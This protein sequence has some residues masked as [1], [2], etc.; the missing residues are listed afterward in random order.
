MS[1]IMI[2]DLAQSRNLDR[3]AMSA[4]RGGSWLS[5]HGPFAN[6]NVGVYQN[7]AQVQNIN[8]LNNVGVIG[9]SFP[10]HLNVSPKQRAIADVVI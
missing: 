1:T 6:V 7:I 3:R 8:V 5:E 9:T 10:F 4:V 2:R